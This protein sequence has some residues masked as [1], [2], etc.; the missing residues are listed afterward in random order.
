VKILEGYKLQAHP[1]TGTGTGAERSEVGR[2]TPPRS[3][4]SSLPLPSIQNTTISLNS[5]TER[6]RKREYRQRERM[7]VGFSLS[8]TSSAPISTG[9]RRSFHPSTASA[10]QPRVQTLRHSNWRRTVASALEGENG[11]GGPKPKATVGGVGISGGAGGVP[12]T[13]YVVP[14]DKASSGITR[15]L[16]EILRDLNKRVPDNIINR[17]H[18]T[19]P[20]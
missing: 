1:G 13:N 12:T 2:C 11:L 18:P 10:L 4:V 20:W 7:D 8:C 19:V 9:L 15:P 5:D 3:T 14:L 16:V 6:G 17:D